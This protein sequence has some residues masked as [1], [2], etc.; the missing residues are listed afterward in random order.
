M[1][2]V[3]TDIVLPLSGIRRDRSACP[4]VMIEKHYAGRVIKATSSG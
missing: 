1:G 4:T 2:D 3:F